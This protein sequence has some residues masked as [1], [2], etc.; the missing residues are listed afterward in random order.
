[1]Y[2]EQEATGQTLYIWMREGKGT[3]KKERRKTEAHQEAETMANP[4]PLVFL[5][6]PL[7]FG[8]SAH[9]PHPGRKTVWCRVLALQALTEF[10]W[11]F[12]LPFFP[13]FYYRLH[14]GLK[15]ITPEERY[16]ALKPICWMTSEKI[17]T[18][19]RSSARGGAEKICAEERYSARALVVMC[20][21]MSQNNHKYLTLE[22]AFIYYL[23]SYSLT[24]SPMKDF[25]EKMEWLWAWY[26]IASLVLHL[27]EAPG[28]AYLILM[29]IFFIHISF[30]K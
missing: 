3:G 22:V 21:F 30:I 5:W 18:Q 24:F 20:E 2:A 4:P 23:Y 28:W 15:K 10:F 29:I 8:G 11:L 25:S 19:R 9:T 16:S 17:C 7:R 12:I 6:K 1:M 13:V 27:S 14:D 26:L